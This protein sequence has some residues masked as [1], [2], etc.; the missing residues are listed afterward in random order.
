MSA[1]NGSKTAEHGWDEYLLS[2]LSLPTAKWL[3]KKCVPPNEHKLQAIVERRLDLL[4]P[5]PIHVDNEE[6]MQFKNKAK[7]KKW[8]RPDDKL[9]N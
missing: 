5:M 4:P 9:V 8:Q 1:V 2:V 3:V 6:E 7:Q